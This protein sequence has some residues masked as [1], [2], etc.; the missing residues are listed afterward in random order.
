MIADFSRR[1]SQAQLYSYLGLRAQLDVEHVSAR[2]LYSLLTFKEIEPDY[3]GW[4][5]SS[6]TAAPAR[7]K[8]ISSDSRLL[9][10][11]PIYIHPLLRSRLDIRSDAWLRNAVCM[12]PGGV[13][14]AIFE[15]LLSRGLLRYRVEA[16][17]FLLD[18]SP[19]SLPYLPFSGDRGIA[20]EKRGALHQ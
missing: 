5:C 16:W 20:S 14:G 4:G 7:A 10:M 9:P 13:L 15:S 18:T 6:L 19:S 12:I 11:R 17:F 1:N 2:L 8:H 3:S